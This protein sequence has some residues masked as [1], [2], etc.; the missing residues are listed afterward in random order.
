MSTKQ[1]IGDSVFRFK[2]YTGLLGLGALLGAVLYVHFLAGWQAMTL[3]DFFKFAAL[4]WE[5]RQTYL[6]ISSGAGAG[7]LWWCGWMLV[8]KPWRGPP[9]PP[10]LQSRVPKPWDK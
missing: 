10:E 9:A 6:L 8:A 7:L 4:V 1:S 2:L 5:R 3:P